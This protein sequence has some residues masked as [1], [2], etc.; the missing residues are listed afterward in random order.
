MFSRAFARSFIG[1]CIFAFM[2]TLVLA[3]VSVRTEFHWPPMEG[4]RQFEIEVSVD[5]DFDGVKRRDSVVGTSASM[6]LV[7]GLYYLRWRNVEPEASGARDWIGVQEL[8]V[9]PPAPN[10]L[11]PIEKQVSQNPVVFRWSPVPNFQT[12]ELILERSGK[13]ILKRVVHGTAIRIKNIEPGT[14]TWKVKVVKQKTIPPASRTLASPSAPQNVQYFG[15][16]DSA[17]R[18]LYVTREMPSLIQGMLPTGR[19]LAREEPF[20]FSWIPQGANTGADTNVLSLRKLKK[21]QPPEEISTASTGNGTSFVRDLGGVL[22]PGKYLWQVAQVD[23]EGEVK[24]LGQSEFSIYDASSEEGG[25]GTFSAGLDFV[26]FN[27]TGASAFYESSFAGTLIGPYVYAS[28]F[29][30]QNSSVYL[31]YRSATLTFQGEKSAYSSFMLGGVYRRPIGSSGKWEYGFGL[32][33]GLDTIP[34]IIPISDEEYS[35]TIITRWR[36]VP[37]VRL[38]F[39]IDPKTTLYAS[40]N[41]VLTLGLSGGGFGAI[42]QQEN[43][44]YYR[45]AAGINGTWF[46]PWGFGLDASYL[47]DGLGYTSTTDSVRVNLGGFDVIMSIFYKY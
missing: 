26:S 35:Q 31:A 25:H 39:L 9:S 34:E 21:G 22:L 5:A 38:Y 17:S 1:A 40:I 8:F 45:I 3:D 43:G 36:L 4:A 27:Y 13:T 32:N 6:D 19:M 28:Y 16:H 23:S 12:Y 37:S 30:N 33:L 18:T 41:P 2:Q 11:Y 10:P 46:W 7:P 29:F 15:G 47:V 14:I 44:A 20:T 24:S 42:A